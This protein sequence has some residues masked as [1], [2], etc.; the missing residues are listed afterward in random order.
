MRPQTTGLTLGKYAPLHQGHQLVIETALGEVDELIILIYDSP[1]VTPVPLPVR[2]GWLRRLYPRAR[3][4][5]VWDG[6]TQVGDTPEIRRAHEDYVIGR[7]RLRGIT[8]FYS[9]EFYG[10]HMSRALGAVNRLVDPDRRRVP[11]S[12]TAI[13]HNPYAARAF[14]PALVY[15]D[16]I[17]NIALLGAPSTGKTTLAERLA[18]AYSTVWMPEYGREYWEKHQVERRLT[19]DQL[20]E[21]AEGHLE[22]EDRLLA[23]AN[24]YL[25][26]D[27]T[28]ITTYMFAL[29]YH[30]AARPRLRQLAQEATARYDLVFVC[31]TDIPYH[32]TW[33][34]SG[35][36]NRQIFQK[37]ILADLRMRKLPFFLLRGSVEARMAQVARVL[38]RHYKYQN[39]AERRV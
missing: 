5:E 26:T 29:A 14:I 21:L 39:P 1:E 7:L 8:H 20:V 36:V 3:V 19:P 23:Q 30:G 16:L 24:Q 4:I 12:A 35:D 37:Q 28:A 34:R 6:P 33:D 13:R 17:S 32:D 18:A 38:E 22:R 10:E 11:V 2:A 15:R 31:D 25:F 27:T 9:S